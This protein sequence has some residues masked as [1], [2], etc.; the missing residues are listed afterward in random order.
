MILMISPDPNGA[1]R[2]IQRAGDHDGRERI[3]CAREVDVLMGVFVIFPSVFL[4]GQ[5]I[6]FEVAD[7]VIEITVGIRICCAENRIPGQIQL[8]AAG[9]IDARA[10]SCGTGVLQNGTVRY[11]QL[12]A[13]RNIYQSAV[14]IGLNKIPVQLD[15]CNGTITVCRQSQHGAGCVCASAFDGCHGDAAAQSL[16]RGIKREGVRR[17]VSRCHKR[18]R[19]R[20]GRKRLFRGQRVL[21]QQHLNLIVAGITQ[22]GILFIER[23]SVDYVERLAQILVHGGRLGVVYDLTADSVPV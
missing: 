8:T 10:V 13:G 4:F 18:D 22:I 19:M 1:C 5:F 6:R 14:C 15:V 7:I 21:R 11:G 12:T 23:T 3:A 17:A 20:G 2:D 16:S 9:N